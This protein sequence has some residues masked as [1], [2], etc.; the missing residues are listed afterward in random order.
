MKKLLITLLAVLFVGGFVLAFAGGAQAQQEAI[1]LLY[2][3]RKELTGLLGVD[4]VTQ[5]SITDQVVLS[6]KVGT[7]TPDDNVLVYE[8]GILYAVGVGSAKLT[9]DGITYP[10]TVS[11]APISL[12]LIAGHSVAIGEQGDAAQSVAIEAGQAYSSHRYWTFENVTEEGRDLVIVPS[13]VT[14]TTGLGYNAENRL[15][16]IDAFAPGGGG[17]I[18]EGSGLAW[19]WNQLTGEKVWVINAA[20]GGSCLNHWIPDAEGPVPGS[21]NRFYGY[22]KY[23]YNS[24][25]DAY[26]NAQFILKNEIAAGHYTLSHMAMIY[27]NGANFS[28]FEDWNYEKLEEYYDLMWTSF[29]SDLSA[30]MDGDGQ[31]ET[32]ESMGLAPH[33]FSNGSLSMA[34]DKSVTYYMGT[35]AAYPD[36]YVAL[37]H[38]RWYRTEEDLQNFPDILYTTQSKPVVKP[39]SLLSTKNGG[40][41]DNSFFCY[42]DQG[43]LSQVAYN[44]QGVHLA[45]A[46]NANL[47]NAVAQ[48][49]G[50]FMDYNFTKLPEQ[51]TIAAGES[52]F[53]VPVATPLW[54]NDIT[55]SVTGNIKLEYPGKVIALQPGTGTLTMTQGQR[56][57]QT[58]E[59]IVTDGHAHCSCVNAEVIPDGHVCNN[60]QV[61]IPVTPSSNAVK[62]TADGYYVLDWSGSKA[63]SIQVA[64]DVNAY[65]CLNGATIFATKTVQ[66][67]NRA[68]LT[69]CDCSLGQKGIITVSGGAT[70]APVWLNGTKTVTLMSGNIQGSDNGKSF[71][72]VASTSSYSNFYMYGGALTGG[73]AEK[74]YDDSTAADTNK[75]ENYG[76]TV[77]MVRGAFT[78][79]GGTIHGGKST[80]F[81]GTVGAANAA[82]FTMYGGIVEGGESTSYGGTVGLAGIAVFTMHGGTIQGGEATTYGGAVGISYTSV[83]NM[84]GG[85]IWGGSSTTHGAAIGCG[86]GTFT[87]YDGMIYGGTAGSY[88]GTASVMNSSKLYIYGGTIHNGTAKQYTGGV[89]TNKNNSII[90][91]GEPTVEEIF[92]KGSIKLSISKD[93]PFTAA[94][95]VGIAME[96]PGSFATV[97]ADY[98][99]AFIANQDGYGVACVGGELKL[100]TDVAQVGGQTYASFAEALAAGNTVRMLQNVT[101]ETAVRLDRDLYLDLNGCELSG[102]DL[103]GYKLYGF[104]SATDRYNDTN[105]G[106]LSG[107]TGTPERRYEGARRY[108]AVEADGSYSFHRFY[109][110]ITKLSLKP[111]TTGFGY[112][113]EFY[114]DKTVQALVAGCGYELWLTDNETVSKI[115][116]G[117]TDKLTLRL[118]NFDVEKYGTVPVN[119]QVFMTLTDGTVLTSKTCS[120]SM[121]DMLK[122]LD[123]NMDALTA[124][125]LLLVRQMCEKYPVT[126]SWGI[127][128][129]LNW[130]EE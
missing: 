75:V 12:F 91:G 97:D 53:A 2:D 63:A 28:A 64:D 88:G 38:T 122:Q 127:D 98:A 71:P 34:T 128:K 7:D 41:S 32:L 100:T 81:G 89:Y 30:D 54:S 23:L 61:W 13:E 108:L 31:V 83:F 6:K 86:N 72:A 42:N 87:V 35:N 123:Q 66:L 45:E 79:Y 103:N 120:Y 92:L 130:S 59:F 47:N 9:V 14:Q 126:E 67:G 129:L 101:N 33:W 51:Y 16:G 36:V 116:E 56:V 49:Q 52:I 94:K 20:R 48:S 58:V 19:R 80:T 104:D 24:A 3:D 119:A 22:F 112:K 70:G 10:V 110:G 76:G 17:T 50:E 37:D 26:Q 105:A 82:S 18:G 73:I 114:G 106:V 62:L 93:T 60:Q 11:P 121:Q 111:S 69:I 115:K 113:A 117:F 99:T 78:M 65:L 74:N 46:M 95:S 29:K 43:H 21:S 77:Q 25:R 96:T 68:S 40:T 57:L 4:S 1:E 5:V 39:E 8:D 15:S 55:L 118:Q 44:S 125:Q 124:Q 84:Y 107:I 27:H 102:L 90:L 85:T 109:V